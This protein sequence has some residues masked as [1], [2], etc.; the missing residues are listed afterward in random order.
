MAWRDATAAQSIVIVTNAAIRACQVGVGALT[1]FLYASEKHYWPGCGLP[2]K[3][4]SKC[5]IQPECLLTNGPQAY[6]FVLGV[7]AIV[8]GLVLGFVPFRMPYRPVAFAAP[9]DVIM[10]FM[11]S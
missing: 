3:F 6:E 10:F 4:V 2:A 1:I 7:F 9:W 8:T 11:Y 5:E